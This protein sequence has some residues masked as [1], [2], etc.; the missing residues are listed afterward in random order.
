MGPSSVHTR[1][2]VISKIARVCVHMPR[3][4]GGSHGTPV[5]IPPRPCVL[6]RMWEM[7]GR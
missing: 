7:Q 4:C 1:V 5:V 3:S 6:E 2:R